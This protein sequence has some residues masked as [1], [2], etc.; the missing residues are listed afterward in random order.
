MSWRP[1]HSHTD[2]AVMHGRMAL[3]HGSSLL[4]GLLAGCGGASHAARSTGTSTTS[5]P[6]STT[7]TTAAVEAVSVPVVPCPT[8]FAVARQLST[9][10]LP[11]SVSIS[12]PAS[13]T[14]D[15]A[16]F[17]DTT[18]LMMLIGPRGWSCIAT[19][20]ADG[21]GG[22]AVYPSGESI[23]DTA[24]GAGWIGPIRPSGKCWHRRWRFSA[25]VVPGAFGT[26]SST[27]WRRWGRNRTNHRD[28]EPGSRRSPVTSQVVTT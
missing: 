22:V 9:V 5:S 17:S 23:P 25:A 28:G 19:Y 21:S 8:T 11:P 3:R 6:R 1:S 13:L 24:L 2:N 4:A 16:I 26:G 7:S 14:T 18:G 20:G 15:L 12:V 10:S 27:P